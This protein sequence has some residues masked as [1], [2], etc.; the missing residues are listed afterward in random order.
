MLEQKPSENIKVRHN[1]LKEE[2]ASILAAADSALNIT[3]LFNG[4]FPLARF[5]L[6]KLAPH[7]GGQRI[8]AMYLNR[9]CSE[10]IV[11]T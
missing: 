11:R 1:F 9:D 2:N 6:C 8:Q 3:I 5:N 7:L 10:L 4:L